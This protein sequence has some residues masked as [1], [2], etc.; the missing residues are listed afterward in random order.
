MLKVPGAPRTTG[1]RT[2]GAGR[3]GLREVWRQAPGAGVRERGR[4][5][6][7]DSRAPGPAHGRCEA[8]PGARTPPSRRVLKLKPPGPREPGP[9]RAP[10]ERAARASVYPK[11]LKPLLHPP[12][13][14]C[15]SDPVRG[16]PR[17]L[18]SCPHPPHGRY[19]AYTQRQA[20]RDWRGRRQGR[21]CCCWPR[22]VS[23]KR[24]GSSYNVLVPPS[25][26]SW[27]P[28][29][30]VLMRVPP[31]SRRRSSRVLARQMPSWGSMASAAGSQ[32]E[33]SKR[34]SSSQPLLDASRE[35]KPHGAKGPRPPNLRAPPIRCTCR[36]RQRG[37]HPGS[38]R[39]RRGV[40]ACPRSRE[41]AGGRHTLARQNTSDARALEP[42]RAFRLALWIIPARRFLSHWKATSLCLGPAFIPC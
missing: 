35:S 21:P 12:G 10:H 15:L 32:F 5:G 13:S 25:L 16:P 24:S 28:T 34:D 31:S 29:G 36:P 23:R 40:G 4:R 42:R 27:K 19:P 2:Q 22:C 1:R 26:R 38:P 6:A 7:S 39:R 9:C 3:V 8:R 41:G 17:H 37:R 14:H 33:T 30:P 20:A 18:R 11:G